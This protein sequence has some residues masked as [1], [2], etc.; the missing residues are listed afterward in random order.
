[1]TLLVLAE[2]VKLFRRT[3]ARLGLGLAVMLGA[4]MP[5]VLVALL[6]A[7][8]VIFG[9]EAAQH[10]ASEPTRPMIWALRARN[11]FVM[12]AV[13]IVLGAQTLAG[14]IGDR[15][16]REALL[17][18]VPRYQVLLAKL[19]AL[20]TWD[21]VGLVLMFVVSGVLGIGAFGMDGIWVSVALAYVLT[22]V[23]DTALA[24]IT[25]LVAV[26]TRSVV[27][28]LGG[29]LV[30]L[31]LDMVAGWAM[32]V[33]STGAVVRDPWVVEIASQHP[34]LLNSVLGLGNSVLPGYAFD[35]R[36]LGSAG[37]LAAGSLLGALLLLRRADIP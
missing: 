22:L 15:T 14:E 21:A 31:I 37:V 16:L 20:L 33:V 10:F 26:A 29:L 32:F 12:H 27:A 2:Q 23:A 3:P 36:T 25:L 7:G 13:L 17:A 19:V 6:Q 24:G 30:A 4:L 28:T 11:F 35:T 1:M 18:P 5:I 8:T 9:V 34:V